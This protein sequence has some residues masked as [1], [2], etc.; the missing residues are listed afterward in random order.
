MKFGDGDSVAHTTQRAAN[1]GVFHEVFVDA[2]LAVCQQRDPKGLY[3]KALNGEIA[4]FTGIT[5][6]FERP[7]HPEL[8]LD[9]ASATATESVDT[10]LDYVDTWLI[11]ASDAA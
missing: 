8:V 2:P 11:R 5:A 7:R 6:P 3:V 10:V 1:P 4:E 9:T